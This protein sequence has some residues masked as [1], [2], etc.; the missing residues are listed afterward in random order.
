MPAT[1]WCGWVCERE[2]CE[3]ML[4]LLF[5]YCFVIGNAN[6]PLRANYVNFNLGHRINIQ[7]EGRRRWEGDLQK[8]DYPIQERAVNCKI[9]QSPM[10]IE[11]WSDGPDWN[12]HGLHVEIG[13]ISGANQPLRAN[14]ANFNLGHQINIQGERCRGE[15]RDLQKCDY[16]I[17]EQAVNCKTTQSPIPLGC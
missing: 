3:A 4:K 10:P 9:I 5:A 17:Q 16:P 8:C 14:Y 6:Q 13:N 2:E 12:L 7:G 11:C 15:R 1:V